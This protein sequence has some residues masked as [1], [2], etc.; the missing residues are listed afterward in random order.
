MLIE[1][2]AADA[3][4]RLRYVVLV[5]QLSRDAR[6]QKGLVKGNPLLQHL[7]SIVHKLRVVDCTPA[8]SA[9]QPATDLVGNRKRCAVLRYDRVAGSMPKTN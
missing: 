4:C 3:V 6:Q 9:A 7:E 8:K 5:P 1:V 2:G